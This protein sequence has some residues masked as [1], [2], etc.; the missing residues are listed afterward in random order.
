MK[1]FCFLDSYDDGTEVLPLFY[2]WFTSPPLMLHY[3]L[4]FSFLPLP[5]HSPTNSIPSDYSPSHAFPSHH[6]PFHSFYLPKYT[7]FRFTIFGYTHYIII[8]PYCHFHLLANNLVVSLDEVWLYQIIYH[9]KLSSCVLLY[10][11]TFS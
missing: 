9:L 3:L 6:N 5:D 11:L 8:Q 10:S 2:Y 4:P 7:T 1:P